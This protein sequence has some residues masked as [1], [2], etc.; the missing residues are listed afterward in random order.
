MKQVYND[1]QLKPGSTNAGLSRI[2]FAPKDWLYNDFEVDFLT[3]AVVNAITLIDGKSF[4]ELQFTPF[5]YDYDEKPK[6]VKNNT[7]IETIIT[8][9]INDLDNNQLQIIETLRFSELIVIATDRLKRKR[10]IGNGEYGMI[11]TFENKNVNSPYGNQKA[12]ITLNFE[13]EYYAPF[14][15]V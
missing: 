11:L 7:G 2:Q 4:Y 3:G 12:Q 5:S 6:S 8:G 1:I 15:T 14:Y 9:L 10:L 13:S